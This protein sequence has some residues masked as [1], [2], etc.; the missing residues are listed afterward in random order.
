RAVRLCGQ[1]GLEGLG[2]S[3]SGTKGLNLEVFFSVKTHKELRPFRAIVTQRDS[4]QLH[5]SSFLQRHLCVLTL[6]DPFRICNSEALVDY[7]R[8]DNPGGCDLVS[9]D[10]E[11][12]FYS[13]P[14]GELMKA[15]EECIQ[16]SGSVA[17]MNSTGLAV[18][19]F[20]ELLTFY[21]SST[22][23]TFEGEIFLQKSGICIGSSVAPILSDLY[24]ARCDRAI[25]ESLDCRVLRVFRYVDDYPVGFK[26]SLGPNRDSVCV[27]VM[28]SFKECSPGLSFKPVV[29]PYI[30]ALSHQVKRVANK[31][32]VPVV[33]SA[34]RKLSRLCSA[35]NRGLNR[36]NHC[37]VN[38]RDPFVSC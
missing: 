13:I 25:A 22:Y 30:H 8:E 3:V 21:L 7:L 26:D 37:D 31:Y 38:H 4:W 18:E 32:K 20:L 33:F 29:V 10:V 17:F 15:V 1:L 27:E 24:L 6:D 12:M 23:I 36:D 2:K 14:H 35:V 34:P 9:L 19:S 16:S 28:A 5:V 11:D